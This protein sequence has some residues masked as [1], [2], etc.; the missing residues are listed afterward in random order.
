[1]RLKDNA[2]GV[3]IQNDL[4]EKTGKLPSISKVYTTCDRLQAKG[5]LTSYLGESTPKRGGRAKKYFNLTASGKLAL[6][7]ADAQQR[8]VKGESLT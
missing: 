6:T 4:E 5:F 3:S 2:Y 7:E 1:M 8:A